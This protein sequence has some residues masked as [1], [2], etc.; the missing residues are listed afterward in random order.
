MTNFRKRGEETRAHSCPSSAE[1]L[2]DPAD[3]SSKCAA[4]PAPSTAGWRNACDVPALLCRGGL[5]CRPS[6]RL[7]IPRVFLVIINARVTFHKLTEYGERI[8]SL[9]SI[10]SWR[11]GCPSSALSAC[12]RGF[13]AFRLCAGGQPMARFDRYR[14]WRRCR[15]LSAKACSP[16]NVAR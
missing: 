1:S 14:Q 15:G 3:N 12:R 8:S 11:N 7:A 5:A 4:M 10:P 13:T 16:R 6:V 9:V 2:L